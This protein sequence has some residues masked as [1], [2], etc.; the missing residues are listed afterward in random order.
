VGE[1]FV[2]NGIAEEKEKSFW[3]DAVKEEL[4]NRSYAKE[5][6]YNI[7]FVECTFY[8]DIH[9]YKAKD[10]YDVLINSGVT[11]KYFGKYKRGNFKE[12]DADLWFC[13]DLQTIQ[14]AIKAF[15]AG[16][17][18]FN[19]TDDQ[20]PPEKIIFRPE[21]KKAIEDTVHHFNTK[22]GKKYLWN[23]K[24]RFGKTL[25][26]LEV[27][28]RMGYSTT[29]IVTHRPVVD[30]GWHEDFDKIFGKNQKLY[31]YATR[32]GDNVESVEDSKSSIKNK[33]EFKSIVK[34][35][36][37]GEK[38]LIFFVS[39][40]YLRLSKLVGGDNEDQL[41]KDIM[42]YPWELVMIDEAHEGTEST[43]G[44]RVIQELTKEDTHILS[45]SGT[46]FNLFDKFGENE[47]YT[48]DYVMEQSAKRDWDDRHFGDPNPY[49]DLPQMNILT[50]KVTQD[51]YDEIGDE[52]D[53]NF[54]EFFRVWTGDEKI[55]HG[56]MPEGAK[57]NHFVHEEQIDQ[58]LDR[59]INKST[60]SQYPFSTPEFIENFRHTFW[61]LPYVKEAAAMKEL[62]ESDRHHKFRDK[63]HVVNVAGQEDIEN[64]Q[65]NALL[66]VQNAIKQYERTIT[67]SCGKLTT[68]VSIPEWTAVLYMKGSENTSAGSY[69][70][71][72][73]RVQ[74]HAELRG[75]QKSE[76]YVFDFAPDRALTVVAESSKMAV[77]A[78]GGEK[79]KLLK[80]KDEEEKAHLDEF[81]KLCPVISMDGGNMDEGHIS[82]SE[83][84]A[85][86]KDVYVERTVRSGYADN[87]LYS[88]DSLM[89]L[90]DEQKKVLGDVHDL[91]G[92]M[93]NIWK[94]EKIDVNKQGMTDAEK[95]A[96]KQGDKNDK[97]GKKKTPEQTEAQKK[98]AEENKEKQ[99][100]ISVMRGIAIRI[101]L[102]VYGADIDDANQEITIDNFTDSSIVDDASWEEFMPKGITKE[103]FRTLAPL[104]DSTIFI[105]A[106]K[107]IRD[108][109]KAADDL[110]IEDRI[111]RIATIF[112]YFHNPDK[113]TVLTPWR[114]VNMHM[115]DCLGGWCFYNDKFDNYNTKENEYGE[116][117]KVARKVSQEKVTDD[118]FNDYNTR[119]LEINSKTG[120][121]PLYMAYSVFM[122]TKEKE[123]RKEK[124]TQERGKATDDESYK[125]QAKDDREIWE[126]VLQDNIFVVCRTP[127]AVSI[128]KR[129]LA[130][131]LPIK[132]NVK[133]YRKKIPV[134]DLVNAN[135]LKANNTHVTK[136]GKQYLYDGESVK[137]CELIDVLR[138][139][140][141]LFKKDV[142]EGRDF[143]HVYN[144]IQLKENENIN[145]MKF[146]VIVG[147]PPYQMNI[148]D[149]SEQPPIYHIFYDVAFSLSRKVSL[150]SPAR[151][152]FRNGKTPAK[153]NE[154][155]LADKHFKVIRFFKK[156]NDVFDNV[157]IKGGIAITLRNEDEN[158][159]A[160][161][162][163]IPQE[164]V[165]KILNKISRLKNLSELV[166]SST[167]YKYSSNFKKEHPE[168]IV[169]VSGG[170]KNYIHSKAPAVMS[171]V[172][173][174]ERPNDNYQYAKILGK[175]SSIREYF[176]FREDYLLPPSNYDKFKVF[177][178]SSSGT[179]SFGEKISSP[180][181]AD[182]GVGATETFIS[183]GC[184]SSQIE[185]EN[186]LTYL[187]TKFA[188]TLLS[189][190]KAT[191]GNKKADVWSNIPIQNFTNKSD[192][193]WGKSIEEIDEQ[194][195]SKYNLNQ[196]EIDF[197]KNNVQ[198]MDN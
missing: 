101:P 54:H 104:F 75:K 99:A 71:T 42:Q 94:P 36:E 127:M 46:P 76:C 145:D 189:S 40:Q 120:L 141:E 105:E 25:C 115:S 80:L 60:I 86:L 57:I 72:I 174:K 69:L 1:V 89:N 17:K 81:L 140:P 154:K 63:F 98:R 165:R 41:K 150:I 68:G 183:I 108:M 119:I 136:S 65:G 179:G 187:K 172:F 74:T 111:E 192:I 133:C 49:A 117:K 118:I 96:A 45:L 53:F 87:S 188:R 78:A 16:K 102:L 185:A 34:E 194:L 186:L 112:G 26:G 4:S 79:S 85:K 130:G 162:E 153:W 126:D 149:R 11:Y 43:M 35:V 152:L 176:Y 135:V 90:S 20:V 52:K 59:L 178:P 13:T 114:V 33:D 56:K 113:E 144:T 23:A 84:F 190:L 29:L 51:L 157:E 122:A 155:M 97:E 47:I 146:N 181:V 66:E 70:Q 22:T 138:A 67:L 31:V 55:D 196:E 169:R 163:F 184:F 92:S 30:K 14:C 77:V 191:Q 147:N 175:I 148:E 156:S 38:K 171:E 197:I 123:F 125:K 164:I 198:N 39:L 28:R 160:I 131:S 50:F 193:D 103:I 15:K 124:L 159:G 173:Y 109:V 24:M 19:D 73:F 93:P 100:R 142:V 132:M 18:T 129:T 48:W 168:M 6:K 3:P 170:S 110:T 7:E 195:F 95:D 88:I 180:I 91:L 8:N 44:H 128:T 177:V 37:H 139:K 167:S 62:L 107:R 64:T 137:D 82:A 182:K 58:F 166:Y 83:I 21:Q 134:N 5:L 143:W 2:D 61:V 121:Y 9:C 32:M 27:A 12:E 10:I 158:Y 116:I 106:A 161:G 151:F